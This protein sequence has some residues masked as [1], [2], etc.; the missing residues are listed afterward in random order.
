MRLTIVQVR[1][2]HEHST[3]FGLRA[4]FAAYGTKMELVGH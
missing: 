4:I 1:H 2:R 3:F